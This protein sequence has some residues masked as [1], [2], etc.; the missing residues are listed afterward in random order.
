MHV[1]PCTTMHTTTLETHVL[2]I[3][4]YI[5]L[6]LKFVMYFTCEHKREIML[7]NTE[8]NVNKI[9]F[10]ISKLNWIT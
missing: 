8:H 5:S 3:Y 1:Q 10:T 4:I 6:L 9:S 2:L 7:A